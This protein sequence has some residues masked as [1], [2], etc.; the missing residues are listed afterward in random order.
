[1]NIIFFARLIERL[2]IVIFLEIRIS[3]SSEKTKV[4]AKIPNM[5]SSEDR[6]ICSQ[7][8]AL[9]SEYTQDIY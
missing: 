8:I 6:I 7:T 5:G 3:N 4:L 2:L 1:M 9:F